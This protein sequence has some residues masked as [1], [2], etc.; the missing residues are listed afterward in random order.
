MERVRN[1]KNENKRYKFMWKTLLGKNPWVE[2]KTFIMNDRSY[3]I[4][5]NK[6]KPK[7]IK[8][9]K[10]LESIFVMNERRKYLP[11]MNIIFE[12]L[13]VI[14]IFLQSSM[15]FMKKRKIYTISNF[16]NVIYLILQTILK[17]LIGL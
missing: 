6:E 4:H 7:Y 2:E 13:Y 12:C 14:Y 10:I 15:R 17:L 1:T 9:M 5:L 8:R 16:V 3:M 11:M